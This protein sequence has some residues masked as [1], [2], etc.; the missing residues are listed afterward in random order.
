MEEIIYANLLMEQIRNKLKEEGYIW[1]APW[2]SAGT[3]YHT[4][5]VKEDLI[6]VTFDLDKE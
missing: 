4:T 5:F 1:I 6:T 3:C 2:Y